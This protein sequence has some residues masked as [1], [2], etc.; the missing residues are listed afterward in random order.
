MFVKAEPRDSVIV[1]VKVGIG[2]GLFRIVWVGRWFSVV[3][4]WSGR[5]VL[6]WRWRMKVEGERWA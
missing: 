5:L 1:M 6:A 3:T 2:R 4:A